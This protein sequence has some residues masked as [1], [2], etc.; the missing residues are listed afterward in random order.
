M[1]VIKCE[2]CGNNE[3]L[4]NDGL[5]VCQSC[6]TKYTVGAARIMM[7]GRTVKTDESSRIDELFSQIAEKE[8]IPSNLNIAEMYYIA[9]ASD[10]D[11][12]EMYYNRI[13]SIDSTNY[14]A[15]L[16]KGLYHFDCAIDSYSYIESSF[17]DPYIDEAVNCLS[18]SVRNAPKDKN[19]EIIEKIEW[20]ISSSI[21]L[22][23]DSINRMKLSKGDCRYVFLVADFVTN[24]SEML[25]QY[26]II[27]S[28]KLI[29]S[30]EAFDSL[31]YEK[32]MDLWTKEKEKYSS[33]PH[34]TLS[35][36]KRLIECGTRVI[37][38]IE[39]VTSM[40]VSMSVLTKQV[41]RKYTERYS[42]LINILSYVTEAE[43]WEKKP[44]GW[45]ICC[46]LDR[47]LNDDEI[48]KNKKRIVEW[49][50]KWNEID[51]SHLIPSMDEIQ[52]FLNDVYNSIHRQS[53]DEFLHRLR[54]HTAQLEA[55][56]LAM[57]VEKESN[58]TKWSIKVTLIIFAIIFILLWLGNLGN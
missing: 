49:H 20:E 8:S 21:E 14:E 2:M 36:L 15:W 46:H 58:T 4:N 48:E 10:P 50:K 13:I 32:A 44:D 52:Q 33:D 5:F 37:D 34:P 23:S 56:R 11:S 27:L 28:E 40:S 25:Y 7:A 18:K 29:V 51:T 17:V 55:Q 45:Y 41:T 30:I 22:I 6:G 47:Y 16:Y 54:T 9:S 38:V 39:A 19:K 57:E 24:V 43:H 42:T 35:V 12:V 31:V 3:L 1:K 53:K 26:D